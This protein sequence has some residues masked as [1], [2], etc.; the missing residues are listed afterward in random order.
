M[1]PFLK[2]REPS[3]AGAQETVVRTEDPD[4]EVTAPLEIAMKELFQAK[5]DKERALAFQAAFE[6]LEMQPHKEASDG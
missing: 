1:L 2:K 4:R 6:I 3:S 5:T